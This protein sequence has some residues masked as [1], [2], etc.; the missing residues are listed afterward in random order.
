MQGNPSLQANS[1]PNG[2][3]L[4]QT[5]SIGAFS[6]I[7]NITMKISFSS[8]IPKSKDV[9][10]ISWKKQ[11]QSEVLLLPSGKKSILIGIPEPAELNRRKLIILSRQIITLA[12]AHQIKKI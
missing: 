4:H 5:F 11:K 10:I 2:K 12:K 1:A 3:G 9:A 8:T 7:L 6:I